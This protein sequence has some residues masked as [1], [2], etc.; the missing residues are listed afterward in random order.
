MTSS[1]NSAAINE[2][3][4]VAGQDNDT[5]VFRDNFDT[6]KTNFSYAKTEIEDLQ[7]NVVRSDI[8]N[9]LN[10][11]LIHN[12]TFLNNIETIVPPGG[13]ITSGTIPVEF[14][15]GTYQC[16]VVG[17]D[18]DLAFAGF[19]NAGTGVG[20]VTLE[21]YGDGTTRKLTFMMSDAATMKKNGFP[22]VVGGHDFE[23]T[24]DTDP[25]IVEV[26]RHSEGN[27]FAKYIGTFE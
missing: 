2:N 16:F 10:G 25:V 8:D 1:I 7:D 21:L 4:P 11:N 6:I 27:Y 12:A 9:D 22:S 18:S 26:W 20:K 5:Q 17:D 19:P 3:F 14:A 15:S 13:S 24:S 23:V